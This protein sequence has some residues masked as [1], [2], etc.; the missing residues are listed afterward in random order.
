MCIV[1]SVATIV[2]LLPTNAFAAGSPLESETFANNSTAAGQWSLPT[3]QGGTNG[4]CLTAGPVSA[5][6]SIPNCASPPDTSG[7]GAL[8]LTTNAGNAVGAVFYQA[9]LPTTQGLDVTLDTYQFNGTGADGIVFA[10]DAANPA[11]PTPP[12]STGPLGGNLGYAAAQ[13]GSGAAG[14]PYGYLGIALDVYGNYENTPLA[15]GSGCT[16]PSPLVANKAYPEVGD[17]RGP[18]NGTV[19]YCILGTTAT[20]LQPVVRRW[21]LQ[22]DDQQRRPRA[23]PRQAVRDNA[24]GRHG[25]RRDGDQPIRG[26]HHDGKRPLRACNVVAHRVHADRHGDAADA[27]G[28][29]AH[30]VEQRGARDLPRVVDQPRH[31]N[32]VPADVRLDGIDRW[33]Q[34]VPRGQPAGGDDSCRCRAGPVDRGFRQRGRAHARRQQRSIHPGARRRVDRRIRGRTRSPSP[35]PCL[36]A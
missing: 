11:N 3:G 32:P 26:G 13:G 31:G 18:G 2:A 29:A 20:T 8:R 36:R 5:T 35:T 30:D 12:A 6:T 27:D 4:A 19:G 33:L 22:R 23:D 7:N 10:L 28:R 15:G 9:S 21:Q 16:I 24:N 1:T 14:M 17:A 25:P 34:R